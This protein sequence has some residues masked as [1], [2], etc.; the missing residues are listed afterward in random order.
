MALAGDLPVGR[1]VRAAVVGAGVYGATIAVELARAGHQVD[2][3]ERHRDLLG[4]ATRQQ[5]A[6]LH[7]G[8]HYPRSLPTALAAKADAQA[9]AVRFPGAVNRRNAHYYAIAS[10]GSLT[11]ADEYL[12]FCEQLDA[13]AQVCKPPSLL[14][15]VDVCVRVPEALVN[16][17]AL[18]E[19]LRAELRQAKVRFR[20]PADVNPG[21]LDHDLVVVATYGRG[22]PAPLRFE[23]CE[24]VMVLGLT[25][26]AF[27]SFVVLDGESGCSLDPLPTARGHLLYHVTES[28]HAANEGLTAEIPGHLAPLLDRGVVPTG[29][30]RVRAVL[31]GARRHFPALAGATYAGSLFTVR[32]VLPGVDATDER[33][34]RLLR[35]GHLVHVLAGKI[36]GAPAAAARIVAMASDLVR[37]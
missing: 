10:E 31:A 20:P 24:V 25:A 32:A 11:G 26:H 36:D 34:T 9:F 14:A 7:S 28:V 35:D 27:T 13:G 12:A 6:R 23:V 37:A 5:Q 21:K 19:Q 8:F 33:P 30:S 2:L 29:G 4:G 18:R 22:W 1:Y 15:G 3:Y 16:V 17:T